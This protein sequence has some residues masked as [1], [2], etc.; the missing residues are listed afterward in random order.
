MAAAKKIDN[1]A[2]R[3]GTG[4]TSTTSYQ[5]YARINDRIRN[6]AQN[7]QNMEVWQDMRG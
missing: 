7:L 1:R 2:I 5:G 4:G 6:A 3:K